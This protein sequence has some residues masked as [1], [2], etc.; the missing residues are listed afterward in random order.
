MTTANFFPSDLFAIHRVIQNTQIIYAKE[1]L[2][3][4]LREYF[5]QDTKYHYV[6][7]QWGNPKVIDATDINPEA[8]INDDE[9]TRIW[10]GQENKQ[11][12]RFLP[13][14]IV[15]HTGA[16]YKPISFNQNR[17]CIQYTKRLFTDGYG[18]DYTI[19]TPQYF[20]FDGAWDTNFDIDIETDDPPD[21]ST[22]SECISIFFQSIAIDKLHFNGLFVKN[23]RVGGESSED[24]KNG[25]IYKQT[26][27]LEC[28]G[29]YRRIVP[30]ENI[31]DIINVCIDF[32]STLP[33]AG[34]GYA[35]NLRINLQLSLL[36]VAYDV[37]L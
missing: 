6:K 15:K 22:L 35:E 23:T 32:S 10:I 11:E 9:M 21:R 7:D 36:D 34:D 17:D 13:S 18:N 8:G 27:S 26:V 1:L 28:R 33:P 5:A 29:E 31:I 30:V 19:P 25:K 37:P 14:A 3:S 24:F 2:V 16:T 4:S 20:M 12:T